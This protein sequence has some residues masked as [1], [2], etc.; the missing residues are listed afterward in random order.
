MCK[1]LDDS[2][3]CHPVKTIPAEIPHFYLQGCARAEGTCGGG[4][5]AGFLVPLLCFLIGLM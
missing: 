4:G 2:S 5:V 3:C 1:I